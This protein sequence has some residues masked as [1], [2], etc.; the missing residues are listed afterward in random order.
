MMLRKALFTTILI[1]VCFVSQTFSHTVDLAP[2][3]RGEARTTYQKWTFDDPSPIVP[4]PN[5]A[6]DAIAEITVGQFGSGWWFNEL[7]LGQETTGYWD[8][9]GIDGSIVLDVDNFRDGEYKL[10]SL[11]ITYYEA[12]GGAP[13]VDMIPGATPYEEA[14]WQEVIVDSDQLGVWKVWQSTW[15]MMPNPAFEEI[16][17]MGDPAGSI[18]DQIIVDTICVPEPATLGL[19]IM[20]GVALLKKRN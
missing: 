5:G 18:I 17:I 11:Q 8:I 3:W 14:N 1:S 13:V 12:I 20:G 2:S 6:G 7:E 4:F 10:I 16:I 19:L 9:G 15:M